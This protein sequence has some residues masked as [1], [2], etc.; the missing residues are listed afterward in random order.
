M[1][2]TT[3]TKIEVVCLNRKY[4]F[5][6]FKDLLLQNLS[7]PFLNLCP[8]SKWIRCGGGSLPLT[9]RN[10]ICFFKVTCLLC[11][12]TQKSRALTDTAA[13]SLAR[14]ATHA[15]Y[16]MSNGLVIS[17]PALKTTGR[18]QGLLSL[19]YFRGRS[20]EYREF[21][22]PEWL[23][24]KLSPHSGALSIKRGHKVF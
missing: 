3:F 19:S 15:N 5:N 8:T 14:I 12:I 10:Y 13:Q 9:P 20:N 2:K 23:K 16:R 24:K 22:G 21:L 17:V 4:N 6:V 7:G 11:Y 1:W 18:L